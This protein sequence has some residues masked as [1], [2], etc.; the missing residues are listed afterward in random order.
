[1]GEKLSKKQRRQ[2]REERMGGR[3]GVRVAGKGKQARPRCRQRNDFEKQYPL[4]YF[5]AQRVSLLALPLSLSLFLSSSRSHC[6]SRSPSLVSELAHCIF[7]QFICASMKPQDAC[8]LPTSLHSPYNTPLAP[9]PAWPPLSA[10][11]RN[12]ILKGF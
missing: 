12:T 4:A 8:P 2:Q 3:K 7:L 11:P 1:M 6:L 5:L 10:M 9:P